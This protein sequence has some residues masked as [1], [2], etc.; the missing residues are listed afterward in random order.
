MAGGDLPPAA[1]VELA[2]RA[3]RLSAQVNL[4]S[5]GPRLAGVRTQA[6]AGTLRDC[7]PTGGRASWSELGASIAV[8]TVHALAR[9]YRRATLKPSGPHAC[10]KS[11]PA[12]AVDG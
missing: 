9:Q 11:W 12:V 3:A 4:V 8:P 5:V 6:N 2:R 1:F 7:E 10:L